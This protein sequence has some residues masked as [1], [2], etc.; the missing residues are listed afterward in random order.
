MKSLD[1]EREAL[2]M[3]PYDVYHGIYHRGHVGLLGAVMLRSGGTYVMMERFELD[4]FLVL[5]YQYRSTVLGGM[6]PV[7]HSLNMAPPGTESLSNMPG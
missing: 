6:S 5:A 4:H 1:V 3:R 2:R 7:I